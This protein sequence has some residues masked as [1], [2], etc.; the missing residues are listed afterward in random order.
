MEITVGETTTFQ[1]LTRQDKF[2]VILYR[3]G[4]VMT[5]I[6]IAII[7]LAS[8]KRNAANSSQWLSL[9]IILLYISAG[10]SVF[11]IHLYV[12]AFHR[13]LKKVYYAAIA[14]LAILFILGNGDIPAAFADKSYSHLLLIPLSACIGFV[15]AKEAFCFKL[16]EGYILALTMPVYLLALSV[17][18]VDMKIAAYWLLIIAVLLVIFTLR[19]VSM[20]LHYDIGDKSAYN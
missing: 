8:L 17:K 9:A 3:A 2:T 7:A 11:F 15:T 4:I 12:S 10:L 14:A 5:T 6:I 20:P 16:T 19:K 18:A 13:A 1:P